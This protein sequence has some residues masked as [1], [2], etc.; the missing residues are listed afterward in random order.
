MIWES[1]TRHYREEHLVVDRREELSDIKSNDASLQPLSP[2]GANQVGKEKPRIFSG[3]LTDPPELM[4]KKEL[5]LDTIKLEA[6][7][8]H[9]LYKLPQGVQQHD[10]P[11]RPRG[12]IRRL[13]RLRNNH[14]VRNLEIA[15]PMTVLHARIGQSEEDLPD[16]RIGHDLLEVP[17]RNVIGTRSRPGGAQGQSLTHLSIRKRGPHPLLGGGDILQNIWDHSLATGRVVSPV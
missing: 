3:P 8:D 1:L 4:R 7:R 9:F 6:G 5:E 14:R 17:P 13:P 16:C 11:E 15:R 2:P 12:L 10:R